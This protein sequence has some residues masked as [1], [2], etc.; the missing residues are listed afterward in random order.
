MYILIR[1]RI[2]KLIILILLGLFTIKYFLFN[3]L[4]KVKYDKP[5]QM[6][7]VESQFMSYETRDFVSQFNLSIFKYFYESQT[8]KKVTDHDAFYA[9]YSKDVYGYN[10]DMSDRISLN[11]FIPDLRD[12]L[13]GIEQYYSDL[14]T[15]SV[16]IVF[17]NEGL[18]TLLRTVHS[19]IRMSPRNLLKEIVMVDDNSD[20]ENLKF[21][22]DKYIETHLRPVLNVIIFRSNERIGLIEA[23][24]TGAKLSS[25]EVVVFLDAHCECNYNWLVPLL[26]PIAENNNVMTVPYID[27]INYENFDITRV[28]SPGSYF[29]GIFEWGMLYKETSINFEQINNRKSPIEPYDSPTHAGGL[30]AINRKFFASLG[31]YDSNNIKIWGGENFELSFKL[32]MCSNGSIK[33]VPCSRV[34]HIYRMKMP[35]SLGKQ[36]SKISQI[37]LNYQYI[38]DT[39]MEEYAVYYYRRTPYMDSSETSKIRDRGNLKNCKTFHWFINNVAHDMLPKYPFPVRNVVWGEISNNKKCWDVGDYNKGSKINIYGCHHFGNNQLFRLNENGQLASGER[40]INIIN[41]FVV[42]IWCEG[43]TLGPWNYTTGKQITHKDGKCIQIVNNK[44]IP[45]NCTSENDQIWE[46]TDKYIIEYYYGSNKTIPLI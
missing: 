45:A 25:S 34:A 15:T 28:Y 13:C 27:G 20:R 29:K 2:L 11:R 18:S 1:Y 10:L 35:Y 23:R 8:F 24:N 17:H 16:V 9:E 33:W 42:V 30:F 4:K 19:V 39:W 3:G 22:L 6:K 36:S 44:L 41:N 32:W 21:E 38:A 7:R 12:D 26:Q 31:Y 46:F 14:P 40:C 43:S 37:E 5:V